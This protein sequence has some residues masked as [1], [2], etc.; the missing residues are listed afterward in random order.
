MIFQ[1]RQAG[2]TVNGCRLSL[3]N[4]EAAPA[5]IPCTPC[6][7]IIPDRS[8]PYKDEFYPTNE[9]IDTKY[10]RTDTWPSFPDIGASAARGC[11]LCC[12]LHPFLASS[13]PAKNQTTTGFGM[14]VDTQVIVEVDFG[15]FPS[16]GAQASETLA[17]NP[18][19]ANGVI[20]S[21]RVRCRGIVGGELT[22]TAIGE[23][24]E[25]SV[26]ESQDL[27]SIPGLRRRLPSPSVLSEENVTM[28]KNWLEECRLGHGQCNPSSEGW[29]HGGL[30]LL[31][32]TEPWLP[33]RCLQ[34]DGPPDDLKFRLVVTSAEELENRTPFAALSHMWGDPSVSPPLRTIKANYSRHRESIRKE[35]LPRNFI[36]AAMVCARLGIRLLWI[37]SLC[38]IQ[39]MPE[40][41]SHE[42]A[43]MHMVY[44]HAQVTIVAT[45]ATSSH[46][47]FLARDLS[48]FPAVKIS[49]TANGEGKGR[50]RSDGHMIICHYDQPQNT[51]PVF[52]SA[53][54]ASTWNTRGWTMQ[55]RSLSTRMIH[56]CNTTVFFECRGC[57]KSEDNMPAQDLDYAGS[58]MWPP[59]KK[60]SSSE[61][62]YKNWNS[63]VAQYC[64]RNLTYPEDKLQA[65]QSVA[66]EMATITG[67]TYIPFADAH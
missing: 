17:E 55:E 12:F 37:D 39:D 5:E 22:E 45:S 23:G 61:D 30:A 10:G 24:L 36:D 18:L 3:A 7:K 2:G 48:K 54:D 50:G 62:C 57:L 43:L 64:N 4:I 19:Q 21:M 11:A 20:G 33:T 44:R 49:Y 35:E 8:L 53:I 1:S 67:E 15:H 41:W 31:D 65:I 27:S 42:A 46:D 25:F 40:D 13:E 58:I 51:L 34:I 28:M 59:G 29:L 63:F 32:Y 52:A 66:T 9:W 14:R 16:R 26:F 6:R 38:I 60:V 47:G 56:F